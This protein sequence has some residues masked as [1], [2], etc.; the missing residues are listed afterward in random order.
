AA[1]LSFSRAPF[2]RC[3][4]KFQ[5]SLGASWR[6]VLGLACLARMPHERKGLKRPLPCRETASTPACSSPSTCASVAPR[7]R[8]DA[9]A[10]GAGTEEGPLPPPRWHNRCTSRRQQ[11]RQGRSSS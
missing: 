1:H 6:R 3:R 4:A 7:P 10:V 8:D 9:A 2:V 11:L 5:K